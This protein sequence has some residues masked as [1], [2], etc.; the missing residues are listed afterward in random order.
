MPVS[1]NKFRRNSVDDSS[2]GVMVLSDGIGIYK[3]SDYDLSLIFSY[4]NVCNKGRAAQVCRDW[5]RIIYS[6]SMW[7]ECNED[8]KDTADME[9]MARSLVERGIT[10]ISV[11][12]KHRIKTVVP[13]M[14]FLNQQLYHLV[15]IMAESVTTLDLRQ[16]SRPVGYRL[17]QRITS[18]PMPNL[19][20][21]CLGEEF[22][23]CIQTFRNISQHYCNLES[24][25]LPECS[26]I[27]NGILVLGVTLRNLRKLSVSRNK[28]LTDQS[29][30]YICNNFPRL[31]CLNIRNTGITNAGIMHLAN[32]QHLQVLDL[33]GCR[34]ITLACIDILSSAG[35][36][37][38]DLRLSLCANPALEE[39]GSSQLL[40]TRLTVGNRCCRNNCYFSDEGIDG[41][42]SHGHRH[43]ESLEINGEAE[44]SV[45][46]MVKLAD[47]V[48]NF[49]SLVIDGFDETENAKRIW[50]KWKELTRNIR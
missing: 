9:I 16:L 37:V 10:E 15:H 6:V 26:V 33:R 1:Q 19:K 20:S 41:L 27:D 43:Y 45:E 29:L 44:I 3:L 24:V 42:L 40:I 7:R 25:A 11:S 2:A 48:D 14:L 23:L 21:L 31:T 8:I 32:L 50:K 22:R 36:C 12:S 18:I 47:S 4:L 49:L 5:K 38:R 39:I 17:V 13:P 34:S 35:S 28:H 46:G 30:L